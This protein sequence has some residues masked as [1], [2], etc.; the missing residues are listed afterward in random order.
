MASTVSLEAATAAYKIQKRNEQQL[1]SRRRYA[2]APDKWIEERAKGYLYP[3]MREIALSVAQHRRTAVPSAHDCGKSWLAARIAMWWLDSSAP[4]EAFV[5]T[6]APSAKQVKSILWKEMRRVYVVTNMPGRMNQTEYWI[7]NEMVAMGRKPNDD[8]PTAFQG[9]HARK[10]LVLFDEACHD[11]NTEVL[12]MDG[13]KN[14]S[15]VTMSD[16][17]LSMNPETKSV[18]YVKPLRIIEKDYIG[19]MIEY[20]SRNANFCVTPDHDMYSAPYKYPSIQPWR[21]IKAEKLIEKQN[22][23][24]SHNIN[25]IGSDAM[26]DLPVCICDRKTCKPRK[27]SLDVWA[28]FLGWF[29]SEGSIGYNRGKAYTVHISQDQIN[30]YNRQEIIEICTAL[31][32]NFS[33]YNKQIHIFD[34]Q[35]ARYLETLGRGALEKRIPKEIRMATPQIINLFLDAYVRG[36]G[37]NHKGRDIIYTSSPR[38]AADLQEL[39]LKTGFDCTVRIR[40]LAGKVAQFATHT[41]TSSVDGFV[42]SR[43][44]AI[45]NTKIRP[46]NVQTIQYSGKVYC[47]TLEKYNLLFT[48]RDG[49]AMWSGNCGIPQAL[50]IAGNSLIANEYGRMLAIG[51]PDDPDSHFGAICKPG[52]GWNVISISAFDTPNFTG[53][54]APQEVKDVLVNQVYVDE[55]RQDVGVD[56]PIYISKVLGQ[57]PENKKDGVIRLS[58]L[59]QCQDEDALETYTYEQLQPI[60]LGVDVGAGGDETSIR[61]RRGIVAGRMWEA[62]TPEPEQAFALVVEAILE[63]APTRVKID[64]IG[65]GWALL[66]MLRTTALRGS[67]YN[68]VVQQHI[69]L[70][71]IEFMPVN[72]GMAATE[73]ERFPRLRSQIWWEVG[74]ELSRTKGWNLTHVDEVTIDQLTDP[75]W[76]ADTANRH[77]VES[78]QDTMKRTKK[79]S[80]NRADALLLAFCEPPQE[81]EYFTYIE[82]DPVSIGPSY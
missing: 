42:I 67:H 73:P 54:A 70:Q 64:V 25:W 38:M 23:Y 36:D 61:E 56:S 82:H 50:Y 30:E 71:D 15:D 39:I 46:N 60:E 52:T 65:I 47:A 34:I 8:D 59:R 7:N 80:P 79:D 66:G 19:P 22:W 58:W 35:L 26:F 3:K 51:N 20:K 16:Q 28:V 6:T 18:E 10:V 72:V 63:C 9:I 77:V 74:R 2:D 27:Y 40:K 48:R 32:L 5:V 49:Y 33:V 81:P 75:L 44:N 11:S 4:G 12:T 68:E 57:F 41:A 31:N 76:H 24:I 45:T 78:K 13:W 55:M 14:W 37:Y 53:D 1:A 43:C 29:C 17:F 62:K 69:N 21:R